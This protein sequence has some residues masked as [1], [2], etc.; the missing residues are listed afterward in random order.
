VWAGLGVRQTL[1][2]LR[3]QVRQQQVRQLAPAPALVQ[4]ATC[5]TLL[6]RLRM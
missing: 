4:P 3:Q 2:L 6:R 1:R 5:P